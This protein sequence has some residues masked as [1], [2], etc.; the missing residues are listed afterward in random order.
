[1]STAIWRHTN[2]R[3][4]GAEFADLEMDGYVNINSL[5]PQTDR[6]HGTES[7]CG[8]WLGTTLIIGQDFA[9]AGRIRERLA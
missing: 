4:T 3:P 6:L 9:H 8:D 5:Y 2:E 1:M 7:L